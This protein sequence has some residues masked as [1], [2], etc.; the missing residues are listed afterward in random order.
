MVLAIVCDRVLH[1]RAETGGAF[2]GESNFD[3]LH[4]LHRDDGLCQ[5]PVQTRVP[6]D[7][8]AQARRHIVSDNFENSAGGVSRAIGLIYHGFHALLG[9]GVDATEQDF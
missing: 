1:F 6:R 8:R 3:A 9:F 2:R 4:S 5:P 7:V